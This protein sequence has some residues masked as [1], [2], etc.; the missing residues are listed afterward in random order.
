MVG[1]PS[2]NL[3]VIN[4]P[5]SQKRNR[6]WQD[7]AN[8]TRDQEAVLRNEHTETGNA[9]GF[10]LTQVVSVSFPPWLGSDLEVLFDWLV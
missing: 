5:H 10:I 4:T 2:S 3:I 6:L 8:F 1:A 7:K 9:L